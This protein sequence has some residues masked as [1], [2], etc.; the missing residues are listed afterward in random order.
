MQDNIQPYSEAFDQ[1]FFLVA[2]Q[3]SLEDYEIAIDGIRDGVTRFM[4][5]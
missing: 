4:E 2:N 5:R 3:G 1:D